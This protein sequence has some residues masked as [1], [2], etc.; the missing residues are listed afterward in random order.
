MYMKSTYGWFPWPSLGASAFNSLDA[1]DGIFRL[2]ESIPCLLM[3]WL[4]T[5][6]EHQQAWHWLCRTNDTY[7]RSRVNLIYLGQAKSKIRFGKV[8]SVLVLLSYN[9][10]T[11][12]PWSYDRLISTI[13]FPILVRQ[14]RDIE[15]GPRLTVS[16]TNIQQRHYTSSRGIFRPQ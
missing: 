13:G 1:G 14:Y 16:S 2:W 15:S 11:S 9:S 10:I 5:S 3:P 4:L 6:P 12:G 7:C 8:N